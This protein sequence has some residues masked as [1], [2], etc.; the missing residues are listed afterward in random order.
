MPSCAVAGL[1]MPAEEEAGGCFDTPNRFIPL[2]KRAVPLDDFPRLLPP[3]TMGPVSPNAFTCKA[4]PPPL[5]D[6]VQG[7]GVGGGGGKARDD[8]DDDDDDDDVDSFGVILLNILAS[9]LWALLT[10]YEA[11]A[12]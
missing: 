8:A 11:A 1:V 7:G 5:S 4:L 10:R 3:A 9:L 6:A 12:V 2:L